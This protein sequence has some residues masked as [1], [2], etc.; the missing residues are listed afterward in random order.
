VPPVA[1]LTTAS[2][3]SLTGGTFADSLT[4]N[5]GDSLSVPSYG[6]GAARIVSM[7]GINSAH[8]CEG[9]LYYTRPESTHDVANGYRFEIPSTALGGVGLTGSFEVMG[10]GQEIPVYVNDTATVKVSG[11]ASDAVAVSWLTLFDD[12][13]GA[14]PAQFTSWDRVQAL[15]KSNVG[16]QVT[17][18]ASGTAGA[19]GAGRAITADD[20]RYHA[21]TYYA[22]LGCT[23]Q[24]P[25]HA[26]T[27]IGPPWGGQR[28]GMP[29]GYSGY[30]TGTYFLD[31]SLRHGLPLIPYFNQAD[32]ANILTYVVDS[33]ASTSPK[34]DL[35]LVELSGNPALA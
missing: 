14:G 21:N 23:V 9:E 26:I 13:P 18:V 25:V 11:T 7:W 22:L 16:V 15:R 3:S 12:L 28:I 29:A 1:V 2:K 30:R 24:L 6:G 35:N 32:A 10:G 20:N 31:L 5:S 33:A 17:A 27:F 8:V 19:Y 34:I 4:A